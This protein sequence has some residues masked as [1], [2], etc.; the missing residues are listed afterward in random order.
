MRL[1]YGPFGLWKRRR[2]PR[3]F[4]AVVDREPNLRKWFAADELER[5]SRCGQH[6]ALKARTGSWIICTE[7][8]PIGER[9]VAL[10]ALPPGA[11][12]EP[13]TG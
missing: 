12:L 7:C 6:T 10:H 11:P 5:C 13:T 9:D 4:V 2:A 8:G 3:M 1:H